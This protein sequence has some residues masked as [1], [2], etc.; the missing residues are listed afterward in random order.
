MTAVEL[1]VQDTAGV[2]IARITGVSRI[3]LCTALS[4]GGLTPSRALIDA[5]VDAGTPV[6]VLIR[7]RAGGFDYSTDELRLCIADARAAVD[8]GAAG[9]VIGATSEGRVDH[10]FVRAVCDVSPYVTFHRAFD[11]VPERRRAL[12]DLAGSGAR[13]LLT[14][15]GRPRAIDALDELDGLV[16]HAGDAL[17][18]M[19]GSGVTAA[20]VGRIV[21]TG[22]HA[23]HSSAKRRV[24]E[25]LPFAFGSDEGDEGYETTDEH[26]ARELIRAVEE[27]R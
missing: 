1:A 17:E 24:I 3:E 21:A 16:R 11:T 18:I 9:V 2:N 22:V 4:T 7:P 6:H 15:G 23:V 14:S 19:A 8:A 25:P 10:D 26:A 12:D 27:S 13:R 20:N 5:A